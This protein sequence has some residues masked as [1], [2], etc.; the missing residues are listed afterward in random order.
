MICIFLNIDLHID[1]DSEDR[2][3]TKL[4][5]KRDDFS[6]PIVYFPFLCSNI[7]ATPVNGVY[8]S[9]SVQ[10]SRTCGSEYYFLDRGLSLR[11]KLRIL[12]QGYL[13]V[14]LKL[15]LQTFH[16]RHHDLVNRHGI[17]VSLMTR[18]TQKVP[19]EEQTLITLSDH[20]SAFPVFRGVRVAQ[21]LVLCVVFCR[22][23]YPFLSVIVL[24]VFLRFTSSDY[25]I[26]IFIIFV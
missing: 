25:P 18:V 22:S 11:R 1:I 12:N 3:R 17:F 9:K 16:D 15:S 26:V 21:S 13:V 19:L 14:K 6:F 10:Y 4:Y 2:L 8:I 7:S 24:S 20:Q 23:L 5:D